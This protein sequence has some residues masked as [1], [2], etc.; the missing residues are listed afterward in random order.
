MGQFSTKSQQI[1]DSCHPLLQILFFEVVRTFD[2]SILDGHRPMHRQNQLYRDG[3]SKLIYPHSKH[4]SYPSQAVDVAPYPIDWE[5]IRRFYYFGG[6]VLGIA[7]NMGF[8][9]RWGGDWDG[10]RQVK[11]QSF[12]DLVH[13]EIGD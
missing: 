12:N 10:D 11:D 6:Y 7:K 2:C 9:I 13:F 5:D 3:K 4:N 1:L 8:R